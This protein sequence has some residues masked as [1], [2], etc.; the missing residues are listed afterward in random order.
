MILLG[1][2]K[3]YFLLHFIA[4]AETSFKCSRHDMSTNVLIDQRLLRYAVCD[5]RSRGGGQGRGARRDRIRNR[6]NAARA[7]IET[8][9][10]L[11]DRV[12]DHLMPPQTANLDARRGSVA[13]SRGHS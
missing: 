6:G 1:K 5:T 12:P 3:R 7:R 2:K 8:S 13:H 9:A 4:P 11:N 10:A